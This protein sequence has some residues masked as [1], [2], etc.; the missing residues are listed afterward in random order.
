VTAVPEEVEE[1]I[2]S[3]LRPTRTEII[4]AK[5]LI[6]DLT[7]TGGVIG[8]GQLQRVLIE[9]DEIREPQQGE[10]LV[11][12]SPDDY[13]EQDLRGLPLIARMRCARAACEALVDLAAQG[14]LVAVANA[15]PGTG[16]HSVV[17]GQGAPLTVGLQYR[18]LGTSVQARTDLPHFPDGYRML[19]RYVDSELPWFLDS[20]LFVEDLALLPISER[21]RRC[22]GEALE[23]FRRGL[24]LASVNLL[25]TASEGAWFSAA[26]KLAHLDERL[27]KELEKDAT[28]ALTVRKKVIDVLNASPES[29]KLTPGLESTAELLRLLRN[30][31]L[32]PRG[33][34]EEDLE[35][36]LAEPANG[37]LLLET[38]S[39]L[40]TLGRAVDARLAHEDTSD[41]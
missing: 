10:K 35:R 3:A 39:Y 30:Y 41:N 6:L 15:P 38:H 14:L 34:T 11:I 24:Y 21:A 17:I 26:E 37:A 16:P 13:S 23:A 18:T 33:S 5:G 8:I 20:D 29:R 7:K 19:P 4:R 12:E 1:L 36:Y 2:R 32:H 22:I 27:E 31:G 40:T 25:G 9:A 28:P